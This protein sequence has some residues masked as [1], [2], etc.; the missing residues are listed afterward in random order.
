MKFK[1]IFPPRENTHRPATNPP[2]RRL[3][4]NSSPSSQAMRW[5]PTN[6][7]WQTASISKS[8]YKPFDGIGQRVFEKPMNNAK[9]NPP[10]QDYAAFIAI[11][12]ADQKHAF[13]LQVAG[14]EQ[15]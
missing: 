12:W 15:K 9:T 10:N 11:D 3:T 14:Q 8:Y 13:A 2:A 6:T 1:S 5:S 4:S 7:Q